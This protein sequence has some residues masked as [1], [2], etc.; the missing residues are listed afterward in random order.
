MPNYL[1]NT[2][3]KEIHKL[4]NVVTNCEIDKMKPEHKKYLEY[5]FQVDSLIKSE[6]YNG[7]YWCYREKHT[8]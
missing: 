1:A 3:T 4:A 7:C 2:N 6:G 8:D 5:E